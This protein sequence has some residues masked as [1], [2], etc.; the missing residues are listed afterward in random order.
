MKNKKII[1]VIGLEGSGKSTLAKSL[2]KKLTA[3]D[4]G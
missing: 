3:G 4:N 2:S 1:L